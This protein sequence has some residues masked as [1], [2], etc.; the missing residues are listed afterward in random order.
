[1]HKKQSMPR[2]KRK[3]KI[4]SLPLAEGFKPFGVPFNDAEAVELLFEEYEA[5][6]LADYQHLTQEEAAKKMNVSRPTFTRIY[7]K[8][9]NTIAEALVEGKILIITGG[10]V[11]I[12]DEYTNHR[13]EKIKYEI[14]Q[15]GF[16]ICL[17]CEI[18][19]EHIKGQ[20]CR[21]RKCPQCGEKMYRENS[22]YHIQAK[23]K[24]D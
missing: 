9:R 2:P 16:C 3:R 4:F 22:Y 14:G 19:L 1:M 15:G 8:A 21:Q 23:N 17:K 11:D 18:R 5:V 7:E 6:K 13:K 20:P 24:K 12:D 10:H